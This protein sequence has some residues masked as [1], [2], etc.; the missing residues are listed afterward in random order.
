M[1]FRR[2]YDHDRN[3]AKYPRWI[4][5]YA[6]K[7][8]A[9]KAKRDL[10]TKMFGFHQVHTS[11]LEACPQI[12]RSGNFLFF[13]VF[14]LKLVTLLPSSLLTQSFML[15]IF[16]LLILSERYPTWPRCAQRQPE[17][18]HVWPHALTRL[19]AGVLHHWQARQVPSH[20][21]PNIYYYLICIGAE[22]IALEVR[23]VTLT[24]SSP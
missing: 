24:C 10:N 17:Y 12:A 16:V 1:S 14:S 11:T 19:H 15:H 21:F 2:L 23:P 3:F 13:D 18:D 9:I 5:G 20:P 4:V 6:S 7:S 8:D 22:S